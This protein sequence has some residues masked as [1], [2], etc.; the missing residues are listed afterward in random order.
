MV[1]FVY[2]EDNIFERRKKKK[3]RNRN[4][5]LGCCAAVAII[6]MASV[7]FMSMNPKTHKSQQK[8]DFWS[9]R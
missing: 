2:N 5:V 6:F 3:K 7:I 9:K 8:L 1:N 4:I